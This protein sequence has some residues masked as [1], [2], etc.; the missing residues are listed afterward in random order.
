MARRKSQNEWAIGLANGQ[1]YH[2]SAEGFPRL[3]NYEGSP[4]SYDYQ[5]ALIYLGV[6]PGKI[7]YDDGFSNAKE[8]A[9]KKQ[10]I[11]ATARAI[12]PVVIIST[13]N[14]STPSYDRPSLLSQMKYKH[15]KQTKSSAK[16]SAKSSSHTFVK[17]VK[18]A[19]R[20]KAT[21]KCKKCGKTPDKH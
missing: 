5:D 13:P 7:N 15:I 19:G 17:S 21:A 8:I 6:L 20:P 11:A 18:K 3:G 16:S 1:V 12:S 9:I 2:Q 14:G 10:Q 4:A